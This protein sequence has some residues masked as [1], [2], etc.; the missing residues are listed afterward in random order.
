MGEGQ[1]K[2]KPTQ[3]LTI[4][5][6]ITH[7]AHG[8]LRYV[9]LSIFISLFFENTLFW[10]FLATAGVTAWTMRRIAMHGRAQLPGKL[11]RTWKKYEK[12][13]RAFDLKNI[14][15]RKEWEQIEAYKMQKYHEK[16]FSFRKKSW[17]ALLVPVIGSV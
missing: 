3:E 8:V 16:P 10:M 2:E 6:L 14:K 1:T 12:E 9:L 5:T 15:E 17:Y 13:N 7:I 4:K 11:W